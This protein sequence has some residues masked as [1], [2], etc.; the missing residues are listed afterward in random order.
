MVPR[1]GKTFLPRPAVPFGNVR[2]G[3]LHR[4]PGPRP[5]RFRAPSVASL[6]CGPVGP[7]GTPLARHVGM[8]LSKAKGARVM[9]VFLTVDAGNSQ[10]CLALYRNDELWASSRLPTRPLPSPSQ[11][12]DSWNRL[13]SVCDV[14]ADRVHLTVASVVPELNDTLQRAATTFSPASYLW[15]DVNAAHGLSMAGSIRQEIGA[16]LIAGLV[17]ARSQTSGPLVVVDCGTATTLTLMSTDNEILG[18]AILPGLVTQ[19]RA[20]TKSAP[21]LP[22]EIAQ[23]VPERPYGVDTVEAIQAGILY[24]HAEAIGG[25][26][27]RYQDQF[28]GQ[29]L[30]VF[31]C[32]GLF[33]RIAALCPSVDVSEALLVNQG[34]RLLSQRQLQEA[35]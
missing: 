9:N 4:Q 26:I 30:S 6:K 12:L 28:D 15:V 33:H 11:L 7:K 31:G 35:P 14:T 23:T 1:D 22:N 16:D 24:G 21:H 34:C 19:L 25:L 2:G 5:N 20:L 27:D 10:L 32:G 18:V 3:S 13:M 8:R 29:E 17:A